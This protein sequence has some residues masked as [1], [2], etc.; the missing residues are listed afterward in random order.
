MEEMT[1]TEEDL[2]IVMVDIINTK[3]TVSNKNHENLRIHS[4]I[5]R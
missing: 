5:N 3:F 4:S 1:V 2:Y